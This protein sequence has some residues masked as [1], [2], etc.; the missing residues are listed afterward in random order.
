MRTSEFE[1]PVSGSKTTAEARISKA[2]KLASGR[3]D[4]HFVL[5]DLRPDGLNDSIADKVCEAFFCSP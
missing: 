1:A 3:A 5:R 2:L 4:K